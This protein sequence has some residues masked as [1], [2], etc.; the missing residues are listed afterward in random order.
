[1]LEKGSFRCVNFKDVTKGLSKFLLDGLKFIL[2]LYA[3]YLGFELNTYF[4]A[5][6]HDQAQISAFVSWNNLSN[7]AF[8]LGVG[9]SNVIRTRISNHIGENKPENCKNSI[10]FFLLCAGSVGGIIMLLVGIFRHPLAAVYTS[11]DE[12]KSILEN[13]Y[14]PYS[15]GL[16]CDILIGCCI[17]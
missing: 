3:N 6:T 9:F 17:L 13:L 11:S 8:T 2:G 12:I 15:I 10:S 5:L 14:I 16:L 4:A 1:M 7:I